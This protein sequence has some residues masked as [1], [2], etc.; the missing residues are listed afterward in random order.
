[1]KIYN[2]LK[3]TLSQSLVV[4]LASIVFIT[5]LSSI[6][7][8]IGIIALIVTILF[9]IVIAVLNLLVSLLHITKLKIKKL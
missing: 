6:E 4:A 5:I 1:M 7:Y 9:L 3:D 2:Y 8:I